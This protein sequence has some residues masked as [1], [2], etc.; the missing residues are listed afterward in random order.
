LGILAMLDPEHERNPLGADGALAKYLETASVVYDRARSN[1]KLSIQRCMAMDWLLGKATEYAPIGAPAA[2]YLLNL[3][4]RL[5]FAS[6]VHTAMTGHLAPIF[7][8]LRVCLESACYANEMLRRSELQ[9]IWLKRHQDTES[10]KRCRR[11]FGAGL[12]ATVSKRLGEV[13]VDGD[14]LII[15]HYDKLIDYGGHPNIASVILGLET[16]ETDEHHLVHLPGV[17]TD[18]I[19]KALC[20][21][22]ETGLYTALVMSHRRP[23]PKE[24][25]DALIEFEAVLTVW[26]NHLSTTV[27][28]QTRSHSSGPQT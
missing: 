4:A 2:S 22:F 11:E 3:H 18:M 21:C 20:I 25:K 12:I 5:L 16:E 27:D 7:P 24:I 6:A 8:V 17:A 10:R 19:E 14:N 28:S 1:H 23:I 9:D 15:E 13:L 26:Q